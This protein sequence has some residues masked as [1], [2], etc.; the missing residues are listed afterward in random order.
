MSSM[1]TKR[2]EIDVYSQKK[3]GKQKT[4]EIEK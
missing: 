4:T 3:N 1:K 2:I